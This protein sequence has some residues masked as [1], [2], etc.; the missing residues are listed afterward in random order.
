LLFESLPLEGKVSA[1]Q[2]DEGMDVPFPA[3][4]I[5]K[6]VKMQEILPFVSENE[7]KNSALRC[8]TSVFRAPCTESTKF[9]CVVNQSFAVL[10]FAF[11]PAIR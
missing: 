7:R 4:T 11:S 2:T 10:R 9:H 1:E 8:E 6:S 5:P 3:G